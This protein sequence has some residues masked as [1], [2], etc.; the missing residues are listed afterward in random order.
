MSVVV[1]VTVKVVGAAV[2]VVYGGADYGCHLMI[3]Q[4]QIFLSHVD[5]LWNR[6]NN[7]QK[8]DLLV[9]T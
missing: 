2:A 7:K 6:G 5:G 3:S 1:V 8:C 9:L 4:D